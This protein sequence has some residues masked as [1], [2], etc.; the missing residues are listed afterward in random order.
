MCCS[1][2][3]LTLISF[4][5]GSELGWGK[6]VFVLSSFKPQMNKYIFTPFIHCSPP[7]GGFHPYLQTPETQDKDDDL[8]YIKP[9]VIIFMFKA[10]QLIKLPTL[11]QKK[12]E[13]KS[14]ISF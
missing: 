2:I 3:C 14:H 13:K 8:N 1:P 11:K 9:L 6:G 7:K 10:S 12:K 4:S 5:V